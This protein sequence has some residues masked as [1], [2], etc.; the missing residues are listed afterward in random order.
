VTNSV[1]LD[2]RQLLKEAQSFYAKKHLG[3]NFLIDPGALQT[4]VD[5]LDLQPQDRVLEIGPGL[6]FLTRLLDSR[7]VNI[8]AVEL[9]G[10]C[11]ARL[12]KLNLP[13]TK[14][15]HGDFLEQDLQ[16]FCPD[17][18]KLKVVGNVPYQITA[19]ILRHVLGEISSPAKWLNKIDCL[20]MTIQYEVAQRLIAQPGSKEYSQITLM[21]NYFCRPELLK[22]VPSSAFFPEPEI[23]SAIVRLSIRDKPAVT[24]RNPSLLRRIIQAGFSSRR[25]MLKNNLASILPAEKLSLVFAALNLDPQVRAERLSLPQFALLSDSLQAVMEGK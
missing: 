17:A 14:I 21:V 24:P 19:P 8:S 6:G 7:A 22:I 20:V 3:Q 13:H 18:G 25:K 4:A 15:I 5:A 23:R 9:D 2:S 11:I 1:H 12:E 10:Q 16:N